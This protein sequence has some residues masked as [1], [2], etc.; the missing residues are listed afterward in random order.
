VKNFSVTFKPSIVCR[1]VAAATTIVLLVA[2]QSY[3]QQRPFE[4][5]FEVSSALRTANEPTQVQVY[6][7]LKEGDAFP[8]RA[9]F[10]IPGAYQIPKGSEIPNGD[11]VGDGVITIKT[12]AIGTVT[13]NTCLSNRN[14]P[15]SGDW[16]TIN[17]AVQLGNTNPSGCSGLLNLALSLKREG[18][19]AP[20]TA[21]LE[22]PS[23][24]GLGLDTPIKLT[25]NLFGISR[26]DPQSVP[27][28]PGN[29][30]ILKNPATPGIYE[31]KLTVQDASGRVK[32]LTQPQRIDQPPPKPNEAG[33][34]VIRW[35]AIAGGAIIALLLIALIVF[36]ARRK[37]RKI[38]E[39]VAS[40][41]AELESLD[42]FEGTPTAEEDRAE[43][44][45]KGR[46][47][48]QS[49]EARFDHR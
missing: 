37:A 34:K 21:V 9:V 17:V 42:Y 3:A 32:V 43:V 26:P 10:E 24:G 8:T 27:P 41:Q 30:E 6:F 22:L 19:G 29:T 14:P 35:A 47:S 46:Y 5:M 13:V 48:S 44:A 36:M 20:Y 12:A 33:K 15:R 23:T 16:A 28:A 4:P 40:E 11:I 39:E 2:P 18:E 25:V 38:F 31:W 49:E 1:L 45:I 7:E